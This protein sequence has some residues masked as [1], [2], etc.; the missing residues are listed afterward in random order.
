MDLMRQLPPI[1]RIHH[2]MPDINRTAPAHDRDD[3]INLVALTSTSLG[4]KC[5]TTSTTAH[6][7]S[8]WHVPDAENYGQVHDIPIVFLQRLEESAVQRALAKLNDH[9]TIDTPVGLTVHRW[10]RD[11]DFQANGICVWLQRLHAQHRRQNDQADQMS[12]ILIESDNDDCIVVASTFSN[13]NYLRM[14][15]TRVPLRAALSLAD[16]V[17]DGLH[18]ED[19]V[20]D[21]EPVNLT[22]GY[23]LPERAA[24]SRTFEFK[25][26]FKLSGKNQLTV[27]SLVKL[28]DSLT[29]WRKKFAH[30]NVNVTIVDTDAQPPSRPELYQIFEFFETMNTADDRIGFVFFIDNILEDRIIAVSRTAGEAL[31]TGPDLIALVP[32]EDLVGLWR[33][34]FWSTATTSSNVRAI[35][36]RVARYSDQKRFCDVDSREKIYRPGLFKEGMDLEETIPVWFLKSFSLEQE[37]C[38]R[39]QIVVTRRL[40]PDEEPPWYYAYMGHQTDS[41]EELLRYFQKCDPHSP[42]FDPA[43]PMRMDGYPDTFIAVD[44]RIFTDNRVLVGCQWASSLHHPTHRLAWYVGLLR[45][46]EIRNCGSSLTI[47]PESVRQCIEDGEHMWLD[48]LT[49]FHDEY[50]QVH[51]H[52]LP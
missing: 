2:D 42:F 8:S 51:D 34:S 29:T 12:A 41:I 33:A 32:V 11:H 4:A 27:I 37:R 6:F 3:L 40:D 36:S 38:I 23:P 17:R 16:C 39:Q 45:L 44:E 10:I 48:D 43:Q 15:A 28:G 14:S 52:L 21:F 26:N 19:I 31:A 7:K 22:K 35:K 49:A 25:S 20:T 9:K 5:W 1:P 13:N 24:V 46:E 50:H 18:L 47:D 30:A